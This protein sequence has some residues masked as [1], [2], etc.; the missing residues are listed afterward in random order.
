V[1]LSTWREKFPNTATD[2][3]GEKTATQIAHGVCDAYKAGTTFAGEVSYLQ[4]M[5][6]TDAGL[7]GWVIGAATSS[8]CPE[9][10]NRH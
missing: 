3:A 6:M 1:F 5:G 2:A 9:Y 10:N 4:A 7:A 8:Y